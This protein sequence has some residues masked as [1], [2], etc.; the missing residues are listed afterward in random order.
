MEKH[1]L[2]TKRN[3]QLQVFA[4]RGLLVTSRQEELNNKKTYEIIAAKKAAFGI[5]KL[6][7]ENP[8]V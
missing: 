4:N 6:F 1:S 7:G 2:E 8:S 3:K 5:D